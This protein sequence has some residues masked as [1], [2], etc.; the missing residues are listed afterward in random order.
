MSSSAS[1]TIASFGLHVYQKEFGG[2]KVRDDGFTQN[3][4]AYDPVLQGMAS[5]ICGIDDVLI[6]GH[7]LAW[8]AFSKLL[9]DI[10][11]DKDQI[12]HTWYNNERNAVW[13]LIWSYIHFEM[14]E[15]ICNLRPCHKSRDREAALC[16]QHLHQASESR[17]RSQPPLPTSPC[18]WYNSCARRSPREQYRQPKPI[19][20]RA[21]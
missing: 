21:H 14:I 3:H 18:A 9:K 5:D 6:P 2:A 17:V 13:I 7:S 15:A 11:H 10:C 12:D 19:P 1:H 8:E 16:S 20:S 4:M